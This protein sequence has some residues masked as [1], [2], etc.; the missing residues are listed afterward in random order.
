MKQ[1][2]VWNN[3]TNQYSLSKTLRFE[4]KPIGDTLQNIKEKGIIE[5]DKEREKR[6]NEIKQLMDE[7]YKDFI[8]R[9]LKTVHID[10]KD[11]KAYQEVYLTLKKSKQKKESYEKLEKKYLANQK[12]LRNEIY[13]KI[14]EFKEFNYLFKKEFVNKLLPEW[15]DEKKRFAEANKVREF[16]RWVTYFTGF[17]ENR[18]NVFSN[19]PIATALIY[20]IVHDNFPKFLDNIER[21]EIL[22]EHKVSFKEVEK[23]FKNELNG[24]LD[25]FFS[26]ST[27]NDCLNQ[28]GIDRFNMIIGGKSTED[29]HII[30]GIN[31]VVNEFSQK[32]DEK[33]I[34]KLKMMPLF[35]QILSDRESA[36]FIPDKFKNDKELIDSIITYYKNQDFN[37][38]K[39]V[40]S[41]LHECDLNQIYIR[42]D[43][44]LNRLSKELLGDWEF[45]NNGLKEYARSELNKNT[46]K[47]LDD[48]FKKEFFA[49]AEINEGIKRI[50]PDISLKEYFASLKRE[51]KNIVQDIKKNYKEFKKI[52]VTSDSSLLSKK[53]E[54]DIETIKAFLDSIMDLFHFIKPLYMNS[55][56]AHDIDS[57]FYIKFNKSY[58]E[59]QEIIPLYNKVRNYVTQK[60]FSTKKF[61]LNF[62]CSS[63]LGG[64]SS[65]FTTNAGLILRK[66]GNFFLAIVP[67][68]LD[69]DT[70]NRL[71]QKG[72]TIDVLNYDF[73]KPDNKNIPRLFIRSKGENFAPAV[74]KYNL[75]INDVLKIYD[76]GYFRTE[77]RE[78]DEK[79]YR[80]SLKRLIDYFKEG[81]RKHESYKHYTFEWKKTED[82]KDISEFY[83]D[84]EK[85]C[86]K[87]RFYQVNL[88]V[89]EEMVSAG[90][91][92][93]FQIWNKDFS[94]YSKGRKN[95]HTLYWQELFSSE[96]LK[97]VVYKLNG[98]AELFF[99]EKSLEKKITHPKKKPIDKEPRK[100]DKGNLKEKSLFEYDL[101]KDRRY[102]EDKFFFHC[103]ITMN[104]K[105]GNNKW[106]VNQR[107][108]DAI[109]S[110][111]N[112]LSIDR[113]ERHLAYYTL[114]D[115]KGKILEQG[116]FNRISDDL[117]R[118]KDYHDK[119]NKLEKSRDKARKNWKEIANIKELKEGYLSQIV[120]KITKMA[121]EKNAIIVLE[122][123]NFGFKRGRFKIEKQV[124][125]KFEKMLIDK[126][127]YLVFKDQKKEEPG[128]L[129]KAY[130]LTSPLESFKKLGKQSGIIFYVPAQYTSK[131]C[132]RTGFVNLLKV[133]YENIEK[134]KNFFRRFETIYYDKNNDYFVFEF[135]YSDFIDEM[136]KKKLVRDKWTVCSYGKRLVNRQSS[137]HKG[138]ETAEM[139]PT[140]ELKTLFN[141]Y[142]LDFKDGNNLVSQICGYQDSKFFKDLIYFFRCILQLRNSRTN[143]SEDYLLSCVPDK[144]GYFFDSRNAK[145][146]KT[147]EPHDA[148]ANGAYHIGIKGLMLIDRIRS[149]G[150]QDFKI[151][152]N[153]YFNYI[154]KNGGKH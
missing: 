110:G 59:L 132:P 117:G 121:I 142:E 32:H 141:Q 120:H 111:V 148:D 57:D 146:A 20:R 49:I 109:N 60:P 14:K 19:E 153:D 44:R 91:I 55:D 46:D 149:G 67:R 93:L 40:L 100:D 97:D 90:K 52:E 86:Y 95:L 2:S 63:L 136:K 33:K 104:F 144:K 78:K 6:F 99:R 23:N 126:L 24:S 48:W 154:M 125:Q 133:K 71:K 119:L 79:V 80:E 26:I 135:K 138:F 143:D 42:N 58:E 12:L 106:I 122:D 11:L 41:R 84:T 89:L 131:V 134:T 96:N 130:Q 105:A 68:S 103:P 72:N 62:Q 43:G 108:R 8:E 31:Q 98:E 92:Y 152:R 145:T 123:L 61:K 51:D 118:G 21:Y 3:F 45:I 56:N 74:Q 87:P 147:D 94:T 35:K 151:D 17:F 124:Y 76:K 114:L 73:Q 50:N 9:A 36:S 37:K 69:K 129:L 30:K 15:L 34:R 77:Y 65:S 47:K 140:K 27:F 18:K 29:G 107:V 1:K 75:P 10:Q 25:A 115:P 102:T 101:I 7:Y 66:D 22:K 112:V 70:V 81:F 16:G 128:G 127:N 150:K 85:S 53:R 83:H 82:Y 28:E 4:L 64:W 38:L 5:E 39:N 54:K 116:S 13:K 137:K 88:N 113:G 139:D